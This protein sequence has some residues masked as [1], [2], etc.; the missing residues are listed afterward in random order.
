MVNRGKVVSR[1]GAFGALV[2]AGCE[3]NGGVQI[4]NGE[5]SHIGRL[6]L[7][8]LIYAIILSFTA[9]KGVRKTHSHRNGRIEKKQA[10]MFAGSKNNCRFALSNPLRAGQ[11]S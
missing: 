3:I 11:S 7:F 9:C 6:N 4:L 2:I 5:H 8:L 10:E 1:E